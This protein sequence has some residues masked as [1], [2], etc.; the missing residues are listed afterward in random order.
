MTQ[1][2]IGTGSDLIAAIDVGTTKVCTVLARKSK[3]G[4]P[5]LVSFSDVPCS[6]VKRGNVIDVA[7]ISDAIRKTVGEIRSNV[8]IDVRSAYLSITGSHISYEN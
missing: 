3:N 4:F 7:A 6:G 2:L 5:E 8:G 1:G